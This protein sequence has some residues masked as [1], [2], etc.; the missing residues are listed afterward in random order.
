MLLFSAVSV[1]AQKPEPAPTGTVT[2]RVIFAD[3]LQPARLVEVTLA[4]RPEKA[5]VEAEQR[6]LRTGKRPER[7]APMITSVSGRTG[8][9]GTFII[10]NVPPAE[11]YAVAKLAGYVLPIQPIT[12]EKMAEDPDTVMREVPHVN[13]RASATAEVNLELHRGGSISGRLQFEDGAPIVDA[14]IRAEPAEATNDDL[15]VRPYY[16]EQAL[17]I[18][19]DRVLSDSDGRFTIVS[20]R[21]G[22]YTVRAD[23]VSSGGDIMVTS[24][25]VSNYHNGRG[26]RVYLPLYAPAAFFRKDSQIIEI[27]GAERVE[28][29]VIELRLSAV[30][31]VRG[32]I[33]SRVD[34]HAPNDG[35]VVLRNEEDKL[36]ARGGSLQ[37]D[38]SFQLQQVPAGSYILEV[39][40]AQDVADPSS[41]DE[42][43]APVVLR[44]FRGAKVTVVVLDSDLT[45][46]EILL[47]EVNKPTPKP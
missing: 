40:D 47:D 28:N 11:Y 26:S 1:A 27:K 14:F 6:I 41:L 13:V 3:T 30:H 17:R 20:L 37:E 7:K 31:T 29:L 34:R 45:V 42:R 43:T 39:E 22:K 12:D 46:P 32:N 25:T 15:R 44:K 16:L 23:I 10:S 36:F 5:D 9:D 18:E 19:A 33:L 38:G 21:P 24:G 2:G 4:R 35:Y 8:L